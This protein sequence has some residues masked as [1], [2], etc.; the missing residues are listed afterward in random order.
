M[1][2]I[3]LMVGSCNQSRG[4]ASEAVLKVS[5]C[6]LYKNPTNYEGKRV[7]VSG[8][9][10]QLP[11]GRYLYPTSSCENGYRFVKLDPGALQSGALIE[12]ES[13]STSFPGRN[14]FEAEISGIFDSNYAEDFEAFRFRIVPIEIKQRSPVKSGRPLGAG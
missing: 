9:I 13:S 2:I 6:Q 11:R 10:T 3:L 5:L 4:P 14:E 1:V 7:T 12:L 8:T